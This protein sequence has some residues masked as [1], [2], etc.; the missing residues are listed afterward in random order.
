MHVF[1]ESQLLLLVDF[2]LLQIFFLTAE[3]VFNF[4][5]EVTIQNELPLSWV[6]LLLQDLMLTA[7]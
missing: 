6:I 5:L 4:S 2:K 7:W 1:F 3:K